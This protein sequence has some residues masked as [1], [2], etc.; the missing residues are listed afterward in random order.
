[1]KFC[2]VTTCKNEIDNFP[3]WKQDVLS[4]T[5]QPD[6]ICIVDS[7]STDGTKEELTTW[8]KEDHRVKWISQNCSPACGRN[9]AVSISDAEF[10]ISTDMG[11]RLDL[12]WFEEMCNPF[13]TIPEVD[14]VAGNYMADVQS[15]STPVAWA[16]YYIQDG[17]KATLRPGFLP[18]NRSVGY[19]RLIWNK[20]GGL[21]EDLSFA[22]DDTVMG[23]LLF[24]LQRKTIYVDEA[25]VYWRRYAR[26]QDYCKE[27]YRYGYG[28]GEAGFKLTKI[29]Q[30]V[31]NGAP[32]WFLFFETGLEFIRKF[33]NGWLIRKSIIALSNRHLLAALLIIPLW[34]DMRIHYLNGMINGDKNGSIHCLNTRNK[35]SG[36]SNDLSKLYF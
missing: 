20:L 11:C 7:E 30:F 32:E 31:K 12:R 9:N 34:L 10:L 6:E 35:L 29:S 1:M 27:Q 17:C 33:I 23:I 22:G 36:L 13:E 26:W 8:A 2:L 19:R 3:Q 15:L 16:A 25:I 24:H 5:K 28:N 4:Q 18:S 14:V 21:P